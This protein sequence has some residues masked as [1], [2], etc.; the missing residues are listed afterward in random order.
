MKHLKLIIA[1]VFYTNITFGQE[2]ELIDKSNSDLVDNDLLS[3]SI[4]GNGTKW[5]G[6]SKFGLVQYSEKSFK[7]LN[8]ENSEIKGDYISPIFTDSKGN[9]WVSYSKPKDGLAKF[10]GEKWTTYSAKE[11]EIEDLSI[12]AVAEDLNGKIYFGGSNGVFTYSGNWS[13]MEL[14]SGSFTVRTI[15]VFKDG[16][17]AIGHNSG[18]LLFKNDKWDNFNKE[19]SELR[20][21][22]VRAVK[23]QDN[24]DLMVGY[25]G[26]FGDG[27]FSIIE[28]GKWKHFNKTNSKVPDHM[29]R[30][31]EI[32]ENGTIWMATNNG[33]IKM[34]GKTITPILFR[35]GMY[36]N[37]ILDIA[38]ESDTIWIATN[39]GLIKMK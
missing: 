37:V 4:D 8:Q 39:F 5:I 6:T 25:G 12:I 35:E 10:D 28:N 19:N 23:F 36:K 24:G 31:I 20:L 17:I 22:T 33:V 29:V 16:S 13:K 14:P 18:L 11:M 30:D 26:G 34:D 3:V 15:D 9:V 1:L 2:A 21:G 32:D 38:I 27:G 7:T